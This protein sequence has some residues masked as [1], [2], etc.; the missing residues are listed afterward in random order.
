MKYLNKFFIALSLIGI[1]ISPI[2][3]IMAETIAAMPKE[4]I[5]KLVVRGS[6]TLRKPADELHLSMSVITEGNNARAALNAN[7]EKMQNVIEELQKLGLSSSEYQTGRFTIE[8]TYTLPP[9]NPPPNWKQVINGYRITN[10]INIKTMNLELVTQ[11]IDVSSESG[12]NAIDHINFALKNPQMYRAEI[13]TAAA[14]NAIEDAKALA[15]AANI[16]LIR[17]LEISLDE[18]RAGERHL[19]MSKNVSYQGD[20]STPIVIGDIE[21]TA[22][23]SLTY[24]IKSAENSK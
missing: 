3:S 19:Y 15:K 5:P 21:L 2:M 22:N 8:P 24:E 14:L 23:V 7:N 16:N 1:L 13:I 11:I 6:A 17:I 10:S 20:I 12:A 4:E 9:K 18:L